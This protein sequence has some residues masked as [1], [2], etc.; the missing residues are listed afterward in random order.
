M[1][2]N[3]MYLC[4]LMKNNLSEFE[5][6]FFYN[7]NLGV[8]YTKE[9]SIFS[10]W[11]PL[12][13]KVFLI[14]Y[15]HKGRNL[16]YKE[17]D[18]IEMHYVSSGVWKVEVKGDLNYQYYNY[19]VLNGD[20]INEV[21]DPY[22][23]SVSLNGLRSQVV[24]IEDTNP[25]NWNDDIRPKLISFQASS[26]YEIHI[27][28]FTIDSNSGVL[29]RNRGKFLG[30]C[31]DNTTIPGLYTKTCLSHLKELGITHVHLLP[32]YDFSSVDE[33]NFGINEYNWGYDPQNY[34][35]LEG[36]Y[37]LDPGHGEIRIKEFKTLVKKLH[38]NN[39]RVILDVVYN[40]TFKSEDSNFNKIA[41]K[42]YYRQNF[43]G[44]F[45]DGSGCGNEL[46]SERSMVRKFII[47]SVK[48]WATEYHIDGFRFD[49]MGLHDLET[50]KTIRDELNKI[51]KTILIYGEGWVGGDTPLN[52]YDR[53]IKDNIN[54]VGDKQIALFSDDI[55]D[56]IKGNV[57][58]RA[59]QGFVSGGSGLEETI[60]FGVVAST[61]HKDVDIS[62][63]NYSNFFWAN[64]PYQ[65]INYASSHDNFTLWDKLYLSNGYDDEINRVLMNKL[66]ATIVFTSQGIPFIQGGEE[67]LRSKKDINGNIIENSYN[68]SDQV[69]KIDWNRKN[70]YSEVFSCYKELIKIKKEH[71]AFSMESSKLIQKN[72]VFLRKNHDFSKDNLV[73]F[74]INGKAVNDSWSDIIVI[75]NSNKDYTN[76]KLPDGKWELVFDSHF[77]TISHSSDLFENIFN[78]A[79]IGG[80]ILVKKL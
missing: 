1:S 23:K 71:P 58:Y 16:N 68:S 72:L 78:A 47:D 17:R 33:S 21:V 53:T 6:M 76:I 37:S 32:V 29:M 39:I 54:R 62:K 66:A 25:E 65:T 67:L 12:A 69:N 40:H 15:G 48:Y 10:L 34:N 13:S 57:F 63:V 5:R 73:A 11:A 61:F 4:N 43:F 51:D 27:R 2:D 31:E 28:D 42:Y 30:F 22:A 74:R 60:K 36:S 80:Y 24:N 18:T 20:V 56:G 75:Y 38:D 77:T 3:Y 59:S 55:R 49:L 64:E 8:V 19:L 7:G 45:S 79:G 44:G 46:A 9:K 35:A 70:I 26:I 52:Y 14:I 41:P 50:I